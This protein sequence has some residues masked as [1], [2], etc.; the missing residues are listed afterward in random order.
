MRDIWR[1]IEKKGYLEIYRQTGI[2]REIKVET[3]IFRDM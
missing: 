1:F 2:L 3:G